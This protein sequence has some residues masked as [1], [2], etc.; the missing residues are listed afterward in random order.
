MID[1]QPSGSYFV[2]LLPNA[3]NDGPNLSSLFPPLCQSQTLL[4]PKVHQ[5]F[6]AS[7]HMGFMNIFT[8]AHTILLDRLRAS[9]NR[10]WKFSP[11]P[12]QPWLPQF[13]LDVHTSFIRSCTKPRPAWPWCN[14]FVNANWYK[15]MHLKESAFSELQINTR[16]FPL[17]IMHRHTIPA[18]SGYCPLC[19]SFHWFLH[20]TR[21][22]AQKQTPPLF[23][24]CFSSAPVN[25][26]YPKAMT[27]TGFVPWWFNA[28]WA[29][30]PPETP[31]C[32]VMLS[33]QEAEAAQYIRCNCIALV[34]QKSQIESAHDFIGVVIRLWNNLSTCIAN[35][36]PHF[37]WFQNCSHFSC[38]QLQ[39]SA[40]PWT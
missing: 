13:Y 15:G 7:P 3:P 29:F 36:K 14:H 8:A 30:R 6:P 9:A 26:L 24:L 1:T 33:P 22:G 35:L 17:S 16:P 4:L 12:H 32:F 19:C 2:R 25:L 11:Q 34:Y 40:N 20:V 5:H 39:W 27:P 37:T 31:T 18:F 21:A 28:G 38:I 23:Q 10:Y